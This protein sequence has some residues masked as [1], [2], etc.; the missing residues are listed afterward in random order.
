[1]VPVRES[2]EYLLS[3]IENAEEVFL[4]S[5]LREVQGVSVVDGLEFSCPGPVT[6][7]VSALLSERIQAELGEASTIS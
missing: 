1:M 7:R 6:Q 4:A 2:A 5:S 3:D